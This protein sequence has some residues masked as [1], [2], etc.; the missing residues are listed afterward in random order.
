[1]ISH[2]TR[3]INLNDRD[4]VIHPKPQDDELLS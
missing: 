4:F 3:F 2:V 1:M